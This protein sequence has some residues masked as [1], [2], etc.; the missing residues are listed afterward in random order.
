MTT[1]N[2][3]ALPPVL[4]RSAGA[5]AILGAVVAGGIAWAW[6]GHTAGA[7]F[8]AVLGVANLLSWRYLLRR[9]LANNG[10]GLDAGL[11]ARVVAKL[12]ALGAAA[13]IALVSLELSPLGFV[14]GFAA[15]LAGLQLA[16]RPAPRSAAFSAPP[17]PVSKT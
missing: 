15:T 13:Y 7:V 4:D 10:Q 3:N 5:A 2:P 6:P 17:S 11:I 1:E 9:M 12:S 16:V 8:G 14:A